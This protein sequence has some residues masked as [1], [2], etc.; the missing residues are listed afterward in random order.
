MN[1]FFFEGRKREISLTFSEGKLSR[2]IRKHIQKYR[3]MKEG[4]WDQLP[5]TIKNNFDH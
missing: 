5:F 3:L 1:F 4:P 2:F